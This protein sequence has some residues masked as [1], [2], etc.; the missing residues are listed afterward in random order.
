MALLQIVREFCR[1][2][3][4][5]LPS[6]VVGAQDDTA[7]QLWGLMNEGIADIC[8]RYEWQQLIIPTSFTHSSYIQY[9]SAKYVAIWLGES[10]LPFTPTAPPAW[11]QFRLIDY[12]AMLNHTLWDSTNRIEVAGPL[13]PKDWSQLIAL[14]I[15]PA[16]YSYTIARN[17]LLIYPV[18]NPIGSV[19][20]TM[21]Y[22]SGWGVLN[23][24][25]GVQERSYTTDNNS[26]PW[27]PPNIILQDLKW[28]WNQ[29][30]GLAYAE[31]MRICEEMI[32]NLQ[33]RDPAPDIVMDN[34]WGFP[35][36]VGPGLLV[37]AG[38]W[39]V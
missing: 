8:D 9:P 11:Q 20:F 19:V 29:A 14:E 10:P 18:P 33:A 30:K 23:T 1:R 2:R 17:S 15:T 3:G 25:T 24:A 37:A 22:L 7:V 26:Y 36:V 39:R 16:N 31:D 12:R 28:R 35:N 32:L 34:N 4:L 27:F 13:N 38:N 6:T 21:Q 5:P